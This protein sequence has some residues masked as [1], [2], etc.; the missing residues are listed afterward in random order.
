MS[1]TKESKA[2]AIARKY[3]VLGRSQELHDSSASRSHE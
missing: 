1:L 3:A 2:V